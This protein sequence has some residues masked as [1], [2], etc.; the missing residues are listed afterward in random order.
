MKVFVAKGE[1]KKVLSR[2]KDLNSSID[3]D[4]KKIIVKPDLIPMQ[5]EEESKL[6]KER[7]ENNK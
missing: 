5:R 6:V 3:P 2:P 4:V 7:N 1:A